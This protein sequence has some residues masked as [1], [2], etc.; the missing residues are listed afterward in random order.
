MRQ[1]PLLLPG[2]SS[3]YSDWRL[4][5]YSLHTGIYKVHMVRVHRQYSINVRLVIWR[6][7]ER[8]REI[9]RKR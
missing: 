8:E 5:L 4:C 1:P 3:R 6:E 9:E 2:Q 7:R